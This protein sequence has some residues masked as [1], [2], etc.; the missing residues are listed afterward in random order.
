MN[1]PFIRII[2]QWM[3]LAVGIS[4][5]VFI[6][7]WVVQQD[8]RIGTYDPQIQI[9]EDM[10]TSLDNG[11]IATTSGKID[12]SKSLSPFTIIYDKQG[13]IVSSN[14]YL[15]GKTPLFPPGVLTSK[16][17]TD[18]QGENRLTWQPQDGVRLA[19]IIKSYNDGYVVVGRNMRET[20]VRISDQFN[21][22]LMGWVIALIA[23]FSCVT[24]MQTLMRGKK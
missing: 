20:E 24:V 17:G 10:A 1:T 4:A 19:T 23:T 21:N 15:H 3:P 6:I 13:K 18:V 11:G 22:I 2:R 8:I 14:A 9:A 7:F 5:I 16:K 12:I